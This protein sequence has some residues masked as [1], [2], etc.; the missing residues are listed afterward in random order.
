VP[1]KPPE[2]VLFERVV[3]TWIVPEVNRRAPADPIVLRMALVVWD[4]SNATVYLN[5]QVH[6]LV[7][8]AKIVATRAVQKGAPVSH[9]DIGGIMDLRMRQ[10]LRRLPCI[11]IVQGR[12]SKYH[13]RVSRVHSLP[14]AEEFERLEGQLGRRGLDL[15]ASTGPMLVQMDVTRNRYVGTSSQK[16]RVA[17][18]LRKR[19]TDAARKDAPAR[20]QRHL[21][22]PT[23]VAHSDENFMPLLTEAREAYIAG[24]HFSAIACSVTTADRICNGLLHRYVTDRAVIRKL[25]TRTFGQKLQRLRAMSLISVGQ[26]TKLGKLNAIR[27]RHLHPRR[28]IARRA[29][30]LD[31]LRAIKLLH[32]FLEETESVFRDYMIENGRL[33]PRP[34][35]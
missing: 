13:L 2:Q 16:R 14:E 1:R 31:S 10:D 21:Q 9:D 4:G 17:I 28:P 15:S 20:V 6:G 11:F 7:E 33:V 12:N 25:L 18:D 35:A 26:E 34:L 19:L 24:L 23:F 32:G 30:R 27:V 29:A 8:S 5:E 22:L 3:R